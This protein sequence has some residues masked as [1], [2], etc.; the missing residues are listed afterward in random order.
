MLR[1]PTPGAFFAYAVVIATTFAVLFPIVWMVLT[2]IKPTAEIYSPQASWIPATID[3]SHLRSAWLEKN[4]S[5]YFLNSLI[6][7]TA[8]AVFSTVVAIL[9]GYALSRFEFKGKRVLGAFVL[10]IYLV[11]VILLALP[12]Y[13]LLSKLNLLDTRM[14]LILAVATYAVPFS[15]WVLKGYFAQ[16]PPEIEEAAIVDGASRIGALWRVVLPVA[17]PGIVAT[18]LF[19]F[20]LAWD[21]YLFGLIII[22]SDSMRTLPLA[23]GLLAADYS[24]TD[25]QM[26]AMGTIT[27]IPIIFLYLF[28]Q[29]YFISGLTSGSVKG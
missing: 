17:L 26:M 16:V 8:T 23:V 21:D 18:F 27:T 15:V 24:V 3:W 13:L 6:V 11:P 29:R 5:V 14:G 9:G 1:K 4:F 19:C 22:N 28:F 2:A 20:I 25:G 7:S 12:F 10:V